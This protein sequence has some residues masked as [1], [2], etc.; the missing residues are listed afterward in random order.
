MKKL[1]VAAALLALFTACGDDDTV[2]GPNGSAFAPNI[3]GTYSSSQL[4]LIQVVRTNDNFTKSFTC[5]G[6]LTLSQSSVAGGSAN[7]SGFAVVGAPCP[8]L[9]FP[10]AGNVRSDGTITFTTG[11]PRPPEG[12]CP[13]ADGAE[14]SGLANGTSLS[15]RAAAVVQCPE[16]G[17]HR[18]SYIVSARKT[19]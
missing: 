11:G 16:F 17:E 2:T 7:V 18:F 4:W 6:S 1:S 14:Y 5:Q 15:V 3:A 13:P 9:S 10:L 8:P 12:P 19:M